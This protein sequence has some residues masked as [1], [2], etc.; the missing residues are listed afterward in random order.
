MP[1]ELISR[2][3]DPCVSPIEAAAASMVLS[4]VTSSGSTVRRPACSSMSFRSSAAEP[5]ARQV[6]TTRP[7]SLRR[8]S[9]LT[10]SR[11]IPRD[12]PCT[13]DTPPAPAPAAEAEN[14][15]AATASLAIAPPPLIGGFGYAAAFSASRPAA[16]PLDLEGI[17]WI[18]SS[19]LLLSRRRCP[20]EP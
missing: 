7:C 4:S 5:G 17:R 12:A 2:S 1:V 14:A 11:P 8:R 13:M 3:R 16:P 6:A 19:A 15:L 18:F 20:S 10:N 9:C